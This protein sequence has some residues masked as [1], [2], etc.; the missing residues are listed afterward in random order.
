MSATEKLS[1][2]A[3]DQARERDVESVERLHRVAL[4]IPAPML[5]A[6]VDEAAQALCRHRT[7]HRMETDCPS[8][9]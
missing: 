6:H 7:L 8:R 1:L 5:G 4:A 3:A 9:P 2:V